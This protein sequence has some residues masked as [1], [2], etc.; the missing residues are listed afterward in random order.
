MT[1]PAPAARRVLITGCSSGFGR[2]MAT[3]FLSRG[4]EVVATA[5]DPAR[6][7]LPAHPRLRVARLDVTRAEDREGLDLDRLDCL[8][9]NA[10]YALFGALENLDEDQLRAQMD[11]NFL[12]AVLLTRRV[13]PLLRAS[14]GSVVN[15]S[16]V[17]GWMTFPLSSAYCASKF[18]MEGWAE[19][20][21]FELEPHGVRIH[22]VEPGGHR[23]AFG[24]KIQWGRGAVAAYAGQTAAY[25]RLRDRIRNRPGAAG[26]ERVARLT[27]DLAERPHRTLRHPV[28]AA[29]LQRWYDRLVPE[30]IRFLVLRPVFRR[31]LPVGGPP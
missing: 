9:N 20:L 1:P 19:A 27:A 15:I 12:G 3:E 4:W 16:S 24:D 18:A 26:P 23:T 5:R 10:G 21:A 31:L 8:V 6:V 29:R 17:M 11:T 14:R 13:L 28:G 25:L 7:D 30:W 22:L 2:V